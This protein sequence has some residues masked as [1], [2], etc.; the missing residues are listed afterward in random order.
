MSVQH[1]LSKHAC[2]CVGIAV[3]VMLSRWYGSSTVGGHYWCQSSNTDQWLCAVHNQ[4]FSTV[5]TN[6][7][8]DTVS[9]WYMC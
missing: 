7:P 4:H 6:S 5:Q 2:C 8:V 3:V 9:I 1:V